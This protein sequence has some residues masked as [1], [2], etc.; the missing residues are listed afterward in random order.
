MDKFLKEQFFPFWLN[1]GVDELGGFQEKINL[2][3]TPFR[4]EDKKRVL[5]QFRQIFV[6]ISGY[7]TTSEE[8]YLEKARSAIDF[9]FKSYWNKKIGGFSHAL[10]LNLSIK[11]EER[12]LYDH[13]FALFSLGH[14]YRVTKE[15]KIKS[16]IEEVHNFIQESFKTDLGYFESLDAKNVGVRSVREQNPHMHLLEGYLCLYEVFSDKKYLESAK[17]LVDLFSTYMVDKENGGV[18][19]YFSSDWRAFDSNLGNKIEPGHCYEWCWLL[20]EYDRL[21]SDESMRKTA[22]VIYDFGYK[23]GQDSEYGGIFNEVSRIG[24]VTNTKKRIWP[25]TE[26]IKAHLSMFKLTKD[27]LYKERAL[28]QY[29]FLLKYRAHDNGG[30]AEHLDQDLTDESSVYPGTTAYHLLMAFLELKKYRISNL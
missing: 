4:D 15:E 20:L 9:V 5:V 18:V 13:A 21:S 14:Y 11:Q 30:W 23:F 8:S 24:D 19:E 10:D 3:L 16:Y 28:S 6:F 17:D 27:S 29:D 2:D 25:E 7:E 26:A 12:N 1:H 22:K